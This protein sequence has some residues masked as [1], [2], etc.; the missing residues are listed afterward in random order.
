MG[1]KK[2]T[3]KPADYMVVPVTDCG[4]AC[5]F[6]LRR[7][8]RENGVNVGSVSLGMFDTHLEADAAQAADVA[9]GNRPR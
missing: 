3:K 7:A 9:A 1:K 5:G 2:A 8:V 4:V 6:E